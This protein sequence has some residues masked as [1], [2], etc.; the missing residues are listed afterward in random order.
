MEFTYNERALLVQVAAG[1]ENAFR[2]LFHYY[3]KKIYSIALKVT[4]S[5]T[6]AEELLQ[7]VFMIIWIKRDHLKT[8]N[9]F[10]SYLS[11]ITRYESYRAI[12]AAAKEK[13]RNEQLDEQEI[14]YTHVEEK[15][16]IEEFNAFLQTAISALPAQQQQV[17]KFIKEQDLT[18]E[19]TAEA[20]QLSPETVK[21]HL[22]KA[23][24]TLRAYII[25][26]SES[27]HSI[28]V[29]LFFLK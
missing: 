15:I 28:I 2:Q 10:Q 27:I 13:K 11:A 16:S 25:A 9:D 17:Y 4:R 23:M 21:A 29:T 24:K 19:Q 3:K 26:N 5:E 12:K 7:D 14:F 18:R 1:D 22:A 6:K 8:V 20:M